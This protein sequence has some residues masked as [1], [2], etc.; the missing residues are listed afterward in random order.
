[1]AWFTWEKD[2]ADTRDG[3]NKPEGPREGRHKGAMLY[4]VDDD[5]RIRELLR[6]GL[7]G[8][9]FQVE[10]FWNGQEL[11]RR[12]A[13]TRPDAI[14]LD[15]KLPGPSGFHVKRVLDRYD[16][17]RQIPVLAV[18]IVRPQLDARGQA[19]KDSFSDYIQKPFELDHLIERIELALAR[20]PDRLNEPILEP[21]EAAESLDE[22]RIQGVQ[23]EAPEPVHVPVHEPSHGPAGPLVFVVDD[24]SAL[25]ELASTVLAEHGYQVENF[26]GGPPMLEALSTQPPELILLD[27]TMPGMDGIEVMGRLASDLTTRRIPVIAVTARGTDRSAEV[28]QWSLGFA[29]YVR[30]P[31]HADELVARVEAVLPGPPTPAMDGREPAE[32]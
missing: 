8:A 23:E 12:L 6:E 9:G 25:R 2:S 29:D 19:Q 30:K 13:K 22:P 15:I 18:T 20:A 3:S 21:V 5:A 1:M 32:A 7:V 27:L 14:L 24:D 4:V 11:V 31:F 16:V 10:T 26:E 17:T 28:A